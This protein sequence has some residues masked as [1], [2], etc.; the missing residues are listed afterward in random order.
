MKIYYSYGLLPALGILLLQ[1]GSASSQQKPD[2]VRLGTVEIC[3]NRIPSL[4]TGCFTISMDSAT[5]LS[6]KDEALSTLL[7]YHSNLTVKD[8][9]AGGIATVSSRGLSATHTG[10]CWNGF[11]L[12]SPSL[13]LSDLSLIP[14]SAGTVL[15]IH[16][17][18]NGLVSGNTSPGGIIEMLHVPDFNNQGRLNL[19]GSIS[20]AGNYTSSLSWQYGR[21]KFSSSTRFFYGYHNNRYHFINTTKKGKPEEIQEHARVTDYGLLQQTAFRAGKNGLIQ[22]GLWYQ[23]TGRQQPPLMTSSINE[24][25]L[26]DSVFRIYISFEKKSGPH[27]LSA[28]MAHFNELERYDDPRMGIHSSY[29]TK[30]YKAALEG[31]TTLGGRLYMNNGILFDYYRLRVPEYGSLKE[32][33]PVS[34]YSGFVYEPLANLKCRLQIGKQ[35]TRGQHPEWMPAAGMEYDL[36]RQML[37]LRINAGRNNQLPGMNDRYWQPGGNPELQPESAWSAEAGFVLSPD[38]K[39]NLQVSFSAYDMLVRNWIQW[40][41]YDS[42]GLYKACNLKKVHARGFEGSLHYAFTLIG[43]NFQVN[44]MMA[45]TRSTGESPVVSGAD[46]TGGKQLIY[47]PFYNGN[48]SVEIEY[49]GFTL[50]YQHSFTGK[51]Y[52]T[53]DYSGSLPECSTGQLAAYKNMNLRNVNLRLFARISNVWNENYQVV[54]NHPMPMRY[55]GAGFSLDL[56]LIS[57]PTQNKNK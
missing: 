4:T 25:I 49:H 56:K 44:G 42:T 27:V 5:L 53:S 6:S 33:V 35:F 57:N 22:T 13:G 32:D 40:Y 29:I 38:R 9:G 2:T 51:R 34:V 28:R 30:S 15:N 7:M 50:S 14:L 3:S 16:K 21:E 55:A 24:A 12:N 20:Q 54:K 36:L 46:R 8:Y 43:V 11:L 17:G 37:S 23:V 45:Y 48:F 10:M 41:P 19:S 1:S 52:Y 47:V 39:G 31:K 26:H 18:G